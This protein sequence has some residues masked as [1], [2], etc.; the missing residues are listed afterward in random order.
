MNKYINTQKRKIKGDL[1]RSWNRKVKPS[2]LGWTG[3]ILLVA[4]VL[5]WLP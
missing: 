4:W 3:I 5:T 2:F 1:K